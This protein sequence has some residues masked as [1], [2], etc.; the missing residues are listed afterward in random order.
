MIE[1][2]SRFNEDK[3]KDISNGTLKEFGVIE[4]RNSTSGIRLLFAKP[5]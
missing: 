5:I 1:K 4:W 3:G 2:G